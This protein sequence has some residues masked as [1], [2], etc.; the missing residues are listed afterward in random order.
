MR[1]FS[2]DDVRRLAKLA[3][4]SLSD[5]ECQTFTKQLERILGFAERIQ[6]VNTSDLLAT[7]HALP[8]INTEPLRDD[9]PQ[10][11]LN[12]EEAL[13]QA[14]ENGDQLFKVPKVIP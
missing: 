10:Q 7:P 5:D 12:R 14:P 4:L 9:K 6:S 3:Q 2:E 1:Y 13:L 8:T 11:G